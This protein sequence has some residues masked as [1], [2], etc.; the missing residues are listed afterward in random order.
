MT[1]L[2]KKCGG[3]GSCGGR[4]GGVLVHK[5]QIFYMNL[6]SSNWAVSYCGVKMVNHPLDCTTSLTNLSWMWWNSIA[7]MTWGSWRWERQWLHCC[8]IPSPSTSCCQMM[9]QVMG[10]GFVH[11]LCRRHLTHFLSNVLTFGNVFNPYASTLWQLIRLV[12]GTHKNILIESTNS[13][14]FS[15]SSSNA[16]CHISWMPSFCI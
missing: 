1:W 7:S 6:A 11:L 5:I 12:L 16:S 10:A 3:G 9:L 8:A 15:E 4:V 14:L 13:I 2:E